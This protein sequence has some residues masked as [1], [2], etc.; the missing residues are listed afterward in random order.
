MNDDDG[1]LVSQAMSHRIR[2]LNASHLTGTTMSWIEHHMIV[3][4]S[5]HGSAPNSEK[6]RHRAPHKTL[7]EAHVPFQ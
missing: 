1:T 3:T 2:T 7:P 5:N 4:L 6:I